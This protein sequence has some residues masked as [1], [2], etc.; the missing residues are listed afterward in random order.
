MK[1][2]KQQ[3]LLPVQLWPAVRG[4][5]PI[6]RLVTSRESPDDCRT[7]TSRSS[8]AAVHKQTEE[9]TIRLLFFGQLFLPLVMWESSSSRVAVGAASSSTS[10]SGHHH[11]ANNISSRAL[12]DAATRRA[13]LLHF[14]QNGHPYVHRLTVSIGPKDFGSFEQFCAYLTEKCR[15]QSLLL[16]G[17]QYLFTTNGKRVTTLD[18]LEHDQEYV[19][20][21][22][23]TFLPHPYGAGTIRIGG[24][25]AMAT[26]TPRIS[27]RYKLLREDD[28]RL[29]RPLSSKY[30]SVY[31]TANGSVGGTYPVNSRIYYPQTTT[32]NGVESRLVRIVNNQN[33]AISS[34]VI[35]NLR[36]PKSFDT[37]LRDLGQAVR[38][39]VPKRMF[40]SSGLEVSRSL[41]IKSQFITQKNLS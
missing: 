31:A 18:E 5:Q 2:S 9:K 6:C 4:R 22:G 20:S 32:A 24:T 40:T 13:K 3:Q 15:P 1:L 26:T 25:G 29:L 39:P 12:K 8:T 33:H 37:M 14:Y 23:R 10:S 34:R 38:M 17:V 36:S 35:L 7:S 16:A 11:Q 21:G 28:L 41:F 30:N 27:S 19:L